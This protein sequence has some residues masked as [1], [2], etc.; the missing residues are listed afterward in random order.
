MSQDLEAKYHNYKRW[1]R[2]RH[3][4]DQ[5]WVLNW[6]LQKNQFAEFGTGDSLFF[7]GILLTA[8]AIEK[9]AEEF[10]ALLQAVNRQKFAKGMYP[11]YTEK[12]STSK[13][14]YYPLILALVYATLTFPDNALAKDTLREIVEAVK[15]NGYALKNPDGTET[16]YGDMRGF[17]PIFGLIEGKASLGYY[18]SL[19]V[20]P[21]YSAII[22]VSEKSYYNNF[23]I[24]CQYL[25]YHLFVRNNFERWSL[26]RSIKRF[27]GINKNN[28]FFLMVSDLICRSKSHQAEVE[29]ILEIFSAEHLPNDLD[30]I[31]H[32][33]VLWQRDPRNWATAKPALVHEYAGIDYMVLYQFYGRFYVAS[34]KLS[35]RGPG[36]RGRGII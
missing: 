26:Q 17:K 3:L 22:Y 21:G 36:R 20:L 23:L 2:E 33:D 30:E 5:T 31:A 16:T 12:F 11:R 10:N 24:G 4:D 13:D 15:E 27:A 29:K 28:P 9:N 7:T 32:S 18:L 14:Q 19:G 1:L 34:E 6:D 8:L 35:F 25:M